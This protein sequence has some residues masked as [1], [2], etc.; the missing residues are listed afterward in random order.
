MCGYLQV[1]LWWRWQA[2]EGN[3]EKVPPLWTGEELERDLELLLGLELGLE[4][5]KGEQQ[6]GSQRCSELHLHLRWLPEE[7][8][9]LKWL[10][11]SGKER[12]RFTQRNRSK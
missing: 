10:S 7:A 11:V 12:K 1:F 4:Q 6:C 2:V 5:E 8:A 9:G 3:G